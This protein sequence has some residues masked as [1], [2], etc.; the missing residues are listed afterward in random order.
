MTAT[1]RAADLFAISKGLL[2]RAHTTKG[3]FPTLLLEAGNR[4]RFRIF[5]HLQ[6]REESK[7]HVALRTIFYR[8]IGS[9][10]MFHS[11][12]GEAKN[13]ER[14]VHTFAS[15]RSSSTGSNKMCDQT[16]K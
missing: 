8:H 12:L 15:L 9:I 5:I 10:L 11:A 13:G 16:Q 6:T 1:F 7:G 3:C 14:S 2:L 4:F